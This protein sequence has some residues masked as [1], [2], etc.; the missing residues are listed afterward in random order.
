M[1]LPPIAAWTAILNICGGMISA[2][3]S[4]SVAALPLR[5][6]RW[7]MLAKASTGSP[8]TRM[9]IF[10]RS[11]GPVLAQ[12]VVHRAVAVGDAL[13]PVVEIDED[14]VERQHAGAA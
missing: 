11:D 6:D 5:L 10:T 4:H 14:L 12:F 9:S 2:S 8:L 13:Q 1:I 3:F 7:T